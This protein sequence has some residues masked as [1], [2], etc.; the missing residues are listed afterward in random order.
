MNPEFLTDRFIFIP[1]GQEP[2]FYF[3]VGMFP[4]CFPIRGTWTPPLIVNVFEN[5]NVWIA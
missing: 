3:G 1:E 2:F 4:T 5:I